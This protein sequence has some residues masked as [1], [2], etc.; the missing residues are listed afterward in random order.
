[1]NY[2]TW[3][4]IDCP[5]SHQDEAYAFLSEAFG[6]IGGNVRRLSNPHDFGNY[7]SFEVDMPS[8]Y[9]DIDEDYAETDEEKA[10]VEAKDN[11]ITKANEIEKEYQSKF[12]EWL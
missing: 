5:I 11:W 6:N 1:M 4:T 2:G 8:K 9:E 3:T 10:I 7:P 12:S